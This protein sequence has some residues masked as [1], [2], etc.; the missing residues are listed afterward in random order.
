MQSKI[1]VK[2]VL[3]LPK[4]SG[5]TADWESFQ[6]IQYNI[7]VTAKVVYKMIEGVLKPHHILVKGEELIKICVDKNEIKCQYEY[8]I[9][10]FSIVEGE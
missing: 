4:S 10:N 5:E 3:I 7:P 9:G 8:M 2:Q 6:S 1:E